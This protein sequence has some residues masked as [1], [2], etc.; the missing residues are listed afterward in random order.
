M[1]LTMI[2]FGILALQFAVAVFLGK[3]IRAGR[4]P[5]C[6]GS[7]GYAPSFQCATPTILAGNK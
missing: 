7:A 6:T 2:V 1:K 4:S 5:R 3:C